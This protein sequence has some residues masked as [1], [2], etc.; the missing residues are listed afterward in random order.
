MSKLKTIWRKFKK[1]IIFSILGGT[2]LA[3]GIGGDIAVLT[4]TELVNQMADEQQQSLLTKGKYKHIPL[5]RESINLKD[6]Q[7]TITEY[8]TPNGEVGY[9][10]IIQD[11]DRI[12]SINF[13][14]TSES[15]RNY[16][17]ASTTK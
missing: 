16:N 1:W 17:T 8:E 3:A 10:M 14:P 11:Y 9:Q 6:S 2:A 7:Y 5:T 13:G 12:K 4:E 15:Y